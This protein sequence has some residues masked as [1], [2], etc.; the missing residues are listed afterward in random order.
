MSREPFDPLVTDDYPGE[1]APTNDSS[2]PVGI[3]SDSADFKQFTNSRA[4]VAERFVPAP[5]DTCC[6]CHR[7]EVA[8]SQAQEGSRHRT[9]YENGHSLQATSLDTMSPSV[10][11]ASDYFLNASFIPRDWS[12]SSHTLGETSGMLSGT[13]SLPP[14]CQPGIENGLFDH[15]GENTMRSSAV[16]RFLSTVDDAHCS[17]ALLSADLDIHPIGTVPLFAT[18]SPPTRQSNIAEPYLHTFEGDDGTVQDP[19]RYPDCENV[20]L[21]TL[22]LGVDALDGH[23]HLQYDVQ[24]SSFGKMATPEVF[25]E[26]TD[27]TLVS[28]AAVNHLVRNSRNQQSV[29]LSVPS[30]HPSSLY[31]ECSFQRPSS[32]D[33]E[34]QNPSKFQQLEAV[35]MLEYPP[36][37]ELDDYA[38]QELEQADSTN[39]G[40]HDDLHHQWYMEEQDHIAG[41]PEVPPSILHNNHTLRAAPRSEFHTSTTS[42]QVGS[43]SGQRDTSKDDLLVH[44]KSQGMSYKQIKEIG[45]FS[46]AE[47]TLRGRYRALTKPKEA[48]L[49]RPEWGDRE[50]ELLFEGV[51]YCSNTDPLA[52]SSL[53]NLDAISIGQFVNKVPW[54]QV[55]EYMEGK[56]TYRYGNATVKKKYLEILKLRGTET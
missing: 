37:P 56:G 5:Y 41:L 26:N 52:S 48:R 40:P 8:P 11:P 18:S 2:H 47:S 34:L 30:F 23:D 4:S 45:G 35:P 28:A 13:A 31:A 21:P 24:T 6:Q 22:G 19:F 43:R 29:S 7:H 9:F 33:V 54:K 36:L 39:H 15:N 55:A 42:R 46:E 44:L 17:N 14:P 38:Y 27:T 32:E 25:L 50:I 12:S 1:Y 3:P 10:L 53:H 20:V 51:A 16:N 49:R